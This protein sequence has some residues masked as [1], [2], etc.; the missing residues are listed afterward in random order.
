MLHPPI[1]DIDR[2][3]SADAAFAAQR[4]LK[5]TRIRQVNTRTITITAPGTTVIAVIGRYSSPIII[6]NAMY[7]CSNTPNPTT[8]A[9]ILISSDDST[10]PA[11]ET[12]D[13]KL[14]GLAG[15]GVGTIPN[16]QPIKID[17]GL[18]ILRLPI[19]LKA[20]VGTGATSPNTIMVHLLVEHA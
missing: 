6:V 8:L 3:A 15:V 16:Q 19:V 7:W 18:P 1:D 13:D 5:P 11:A 20:I 12:R 10:D 2:I 4:I 14:S 17:Y 9:D